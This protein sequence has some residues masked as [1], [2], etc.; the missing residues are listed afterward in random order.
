M[1]IRLGTRA[2]ALAMAQAGTVADALS[3]A[4]GTPVELVPV[5]TLGDT[6][7]APVARLGVGVFVSA[8]R[9]ALT[10]KEI[11]VA[12]HSYKDLPTAAVPQ[13][14]VGA[15]PPRE[16]PRDALVARDGL[17]FGDL[18]AAAKV[19]TGAP[20]RVAQL[21]G[22]GRG[23]QLVGIRG[24]IDTRLRMVAD[25]ELD[26][27]ILARAGL[28]RLGRAQQIT[29]TLDPALMLPAPAQGALAVECRVD[30]PHL[31]EALAAIDDPPSRVRVA[32]ERAMLSTLEAGCSAPVAGLAEISETGD[33][34]RLRSAVI[35]PDGTHAIRLTREAPI[36]GGMSHDSAAAVATAEQLGHDLATEL[37]AAGARTILESNNDS[38]P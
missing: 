17:R 37:L 16:D 38:H 27:V 28:T 22:L 32:A 23:W 5:T 1:T 9:D 25:G 36:R 11:D 18:P 35:R 14:W 6:S 19:G 4:T 26:A 8:L 2:S 10:A 12:V 30:D 34:L 20:R 21:R 15:V 33:T 31:V 3:A 7:N 29:E 13:L 24:N